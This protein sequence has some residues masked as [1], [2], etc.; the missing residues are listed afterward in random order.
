[1]CVCIHKRQY[2]NNIKRT[3]VGRHERHG[4][5]RFVRGRRALE[6]ENP[7]GLSRAFRRTVDVRWNSPGLKYHAGGIPFVP[8]ALYTL[9]HGPRRNA[10]R[11][12]RCRGSRLGGRLRVKLLV[13]GDEINDNGPDDS[14]IRLNVRIGSPNPIRWCRRHVIRPKR[15]SMR[16]K[17]FSLRSHPLS[18]ANKRTFLTA[19]FWKKLNRTHHALNILPAF[20]FVVPA[21]PSAF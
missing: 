21:C 19:T 9:R 15:T 4:F 18:H 6:Q 13:R 1:M 17:P 2:I 16:A 12:R 3:G 8:T 11:A 14:F 5:F 7:T 10:Q 20:W